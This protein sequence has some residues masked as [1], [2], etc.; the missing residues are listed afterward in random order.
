[1][2]LLPRITKCEANQRPGTEFTWTS[3]CW[4]GRLHRCWQCQSPTQRHTWD[5]KL[6]SKNVCISRYLLFNRILGRHQKQVLTPSILPEQEQLRWEEEVEGFCR[7]QDGGKGSV[8]SWVR[9][10]LTLIMGCCV[11]VQ[12]SSKKEYLQCLLKSDALCYVMSAKYGLIWIW[13]PRKS[14]LKKKDKEET[15]NKDSVCINSSGC[16]PTF[17]H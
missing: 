13:S 5:M 15:H 12:H 10:W 17:S 2:K 4:Q 6:P 1:M 14:W 3:S 16:C 11:H 8:P 7:V 9:C